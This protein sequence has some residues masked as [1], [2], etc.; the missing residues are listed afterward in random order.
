MTHALWMPIFL[1]WLEKEPKVAVADGDI[2]IYF[3]PFQSI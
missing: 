1:Q 2:S 3:D